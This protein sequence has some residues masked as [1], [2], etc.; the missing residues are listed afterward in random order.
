MA[1]QFLRQK[2]LKVYQV[3]EM[4]GFQDAAYFSTVFKNVENMSPKDF[5][6]TVS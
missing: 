2:D 4:V 3:A 6:K 5:Q 1:K